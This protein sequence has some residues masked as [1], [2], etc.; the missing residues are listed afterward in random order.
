MQRSK[1]S[2]RKLAFNIFNVVVN[3]A[4]HEAAAKDIFQKLTM[5]TSRFLSAHVNYYGFV[6]RDD[7]VRHAIMAQKPFVDAYPHSAASRAVTT[8]YNNLIERAAPIPT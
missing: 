7:H 4:P 5:V 8:L 2:H 3:A 1:C 6:P